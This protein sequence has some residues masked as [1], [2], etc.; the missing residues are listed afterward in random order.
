MPLK[1]TKKPS[2]TTKIRSLGRANM[3]IVMAFVL[4]FA[5]FGTWFV[6]RS[7]AS[8]WYCAQH[9]YYQY[10]PG[11][12]GGQCVKNIQYELNVAEGAGLRVDGIFG[13]ATS[14]AVRSWN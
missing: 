11:T 14:T 8:T 1:S 4:T 3:A 9:I 6:Y 2:F 13:P 5:G 12:Y 10:E 7:E